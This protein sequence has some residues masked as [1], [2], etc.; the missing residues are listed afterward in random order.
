MSRLLIAPLIL[1]RDSKLYF[2]IMLYVCVFILAP[3]PLGEHDQTSASSRRQQPD[4]EGT[5]AV[6]VMLLLCD[7]EAGTMDLCLCL[8]TC[9]KFLVLPQRGP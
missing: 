9:Q 6:L 3:F 7:S 8:C 2:I 1:D 4:S 5:S